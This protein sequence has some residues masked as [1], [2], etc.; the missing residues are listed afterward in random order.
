MRYNQVEIDSEDLK[1]LLGMRMCADPFPESVDQ[2]VI[3]KMLDY[4][5]RVFGYDHWIDAYHELPVK[6]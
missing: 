2:I 6:K 1:E 3:D 5:S 4:F